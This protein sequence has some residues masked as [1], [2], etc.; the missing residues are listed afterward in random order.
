MICDF[1]MARNVPLDADEKEFMAYRKSEYKQ[2]LKA[3]NKQEY[4]KR[5]RKFKQNIT[6]AL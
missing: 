3:N 5:E 4:I 6:Q 2:V 1:G